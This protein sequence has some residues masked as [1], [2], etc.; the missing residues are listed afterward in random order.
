M[1]GLQVL[2]FSCGRRKLWLGFMSIIDLEACPHPTI[3]L[4]CDLG[5]VIDLSKLQ[6]LTLKWILLIPVMQDIIV[7]FRKAWGKALEAWFMQI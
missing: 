2:G 4:L 5:Q 3:H 7:G 6:S 1:K